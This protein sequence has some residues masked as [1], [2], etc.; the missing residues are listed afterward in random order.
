MIGIRTA[1][2]L[3]AVLTVASFVLLKGLALYF[4]LIIVGGLAAKAVVHYY[5]KRLD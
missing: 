5:R 3:F 2:I 4:C 1:L